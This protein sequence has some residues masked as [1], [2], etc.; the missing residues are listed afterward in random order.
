MIL[1]RG[2]LVETGII[3]RVLTLIRIHY[4]ICRMIRKLLHSVGVLPE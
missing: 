1:L 3:V 4:I 2:T